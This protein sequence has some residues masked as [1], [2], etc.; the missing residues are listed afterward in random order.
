M[1]A[2]LK[3]KY[4]ALRQGL[5]RLD[6]QPIGAAALTV[7]LILDFF[8]LSSIFNGLAEHTAQLDRPGDFIPPHCQSALIEQ[9]WS[10]T[11]RLQ[12]VAGLVARYR[13]NYMQA[14]PERAQR[15]QHPVCAPLTNTLRAIERDAALADALTT[16][17]R[18]RGE[19]GK[20]R[21]EHAR[22]KGVYDTTLLESMARP[23]TPPRPVTDMQARS[24]D[25]AASVE[26]LV[27]TEQAQAAELDAH[28]LMVQLY[29][30]LA[31][32]NDAD[33]QALRSELR[34]R[35]FWFP[36]QRLGMELLFLLPLVAVFYFWNARSIAAGRPFQSLVS[37][38]LL[39]VV[40]IPVVF[41]LIELVYDIIPKKLFQHVIELLQALKLVAIWHY[42]VM[43]LAIGAALFLVYI[44]QKKL[45][46]R[47]RLLERR[48]ARG[49]CQDCGV[50]LPDG[51]QA[52]TACG[53]RQYRDCAACGAP[54][55]VHGRFCRSCGAASPD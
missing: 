39:V 36:L 38:H 33:R 14:I 23:D 26:Q 27:A 24:A 12:R 28:P 31:A 51:A 8:I 9:D 49:Q 20:L 15:T 47:Q 18:T 37:S 13:H 41:K 6:D 40:F 30:T 42:L 3:H 11:D 2:A 21:G 5:T 32:V 22:I 44:L 52:C 25:L 4:H 19:L 50:H 46:S 35:N 48:I 43:A 10:D 1:I 17:Q 53:Y 7:V 34:T 29:T 55:Y 16:Y 54:T 45:F